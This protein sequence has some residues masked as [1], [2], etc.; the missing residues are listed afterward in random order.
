MWEEKRE[1]VCVREGGNERER[2]R[3]CVCVR[4]CEWGN[5]SV[6]ECEEL[7][8]RNQQ[9]TFTILQTK[10]TPEAFPIQQWRVHFQ[11]NSDPPSTTAWHI[12]YTQWSCRGCFRW[13][14]GNGVCWLRNKSSSHSHSLGHSYYLTNTHTHPLTE[15]CLWDENITGKWNTNVVCWNS[16]HHT[17][18]VSTY[19]PGRTS[20]WSKLFTKL[21]AAITMIPLFCSNPS[22]S[23]NSW[24]NVI[25]SADWSL[26][27]LGRGSKK[28]WLVIKLYNKH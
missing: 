1:S 22:I 4:E 8:F 19:R 24:F 28:L 25:L 7:S 3:E 20:A 11:V 26:T 6:W 18:S 2:E 12:S 21:V 27:F 15:M 14:T 9:I 17:Q 16:T 5:M 13:K 23:T 10:T